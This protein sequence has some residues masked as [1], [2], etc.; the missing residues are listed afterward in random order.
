VARLGPGDFFGELGA[1]LGARVS[2][3][4]VAVKPTRVL[5]LDR[6]TLE[7][8]CL[9]Q[10]EIAIRMIRVLVSRLIEAERRLAALG[11]EDLLRPLVRP[12]ASGP[13]RGDAA[14]RGLR[15]AAQ[16][17][18]RDGFSMLEPSAATALDRAGSARRR[19]LVVP[20]LEDSRLSRRA[21]RL[22]LRKVSIACACPAGG[23]RGGC[24]AAA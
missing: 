22:T 10:P 14:G 21:G 1:V 13:A 15:P 20:D 11:V 24:G 5:Q 2:S 8:M 16:A 7:S 17:G 6:E 4:A 3:R 9:A 18:G 23:G 12:G 19:C